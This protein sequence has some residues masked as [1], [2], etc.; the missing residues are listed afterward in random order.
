M[1]ISVLSLQRQNDSNWIAKLT[2]GE[3]VLTSPVAV[4]SDSELQSFQI[5]EP[6]F[7]DMLA[8]NGLEGEFSK[9]F[10]GFIENGK[11]ELPWCLGEHD[12]EIILRVSSHYAAGQAT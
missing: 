1:R 4:Q 10:F 5:G 7:K 3:L 12:S 2:A 8:L 11:P 6:F 9:R